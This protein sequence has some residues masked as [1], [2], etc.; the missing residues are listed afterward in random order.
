MDYT[1]IGD[2]VNLA[3]RLESATRELS[4]DILVSE[5]T[6]AAA[7]GTFRFKE[8]GSIHVKG[9]TE[10]VTTYTPEQPEHEAVDGEVIASA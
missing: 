10:P 1:A 3:S 4:V 6:Y 5:Y 9:R 2:T 8:M 7:R